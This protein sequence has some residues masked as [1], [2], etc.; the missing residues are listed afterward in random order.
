MQK[1]FVSYEQALALKELGFDEEVFQ[2]FTLPDMDEFCKHPLKQQV[3][4]WFRDKHKLVFFV[5]MVTIT[6]FYYV[7][8]IYP[9]NT[10]KIYEE[11]EDACIDKLIE[12]VKQK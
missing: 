8:D 7:I 1:E 5:N 4:R 10:Y 9:S 12:I 2:R 3:F 11:A 6:I